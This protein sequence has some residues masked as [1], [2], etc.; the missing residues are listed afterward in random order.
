M[1]HY[2]VY[3][4]RER[5]GGIVKGKDVEAVDDVTAMREAEAD[6]DCPVCE[7]WRGANKVGTI[8]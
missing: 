3:K 1:T 8:D 2:R 7:I 5:D 4:L 6:Q